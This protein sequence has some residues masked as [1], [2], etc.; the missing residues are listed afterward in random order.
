[1]TPLRDR[2]PVLLG[3]LGLGLI[4]ALLFA[5]FNVENLPLIGSG[6]LYTAAFTEAGGLKPG[7]E[8]RI[9]GVSVGKVEGVDLEGDHV[10]V[11]SRIKGGP[12]FGVDTGA[13]IRIK[14]ILGQKYLSLEP[15]GPGQ[16]DP[17]TEIPLGRTVSA[18]DVVQAFS[19]LTTTSEHI[20]TAQLATA[21]DTIS[22]AFKDSPAQV[23]A[24]LQG[25][26][27]LSQTIASRDDVLRQLLSH[28]DNVSAVLSDRSDQLTALIN[29][30][31]LLLQE[32]EARR[33]VIHSLLQNT[34]DLA[35]QLSGLVADNRAQIGPALDRLHAVLTILQ[36]NQD[37]LDHSIQLLAPFVRV[38]ANNLGNGR[39]FDTYI[40]NLI[41]LPLSVQPPSGKVP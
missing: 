21:L 17:K 6:T 39:W 23:R 3:A 29:D 30:G 25:L 35:L 36:R 20:D 2:N 38:F 5:A 11:T 16:L 7:D 31:T 26:S 24:S 28:A 40:Q 41:P 22:A 13:S 32:I 33:V 19:D 14:T 34:S 9:A 37:N 15:K 1:M 10:R 18:Y 12:Q 4:A 8:V 27:R